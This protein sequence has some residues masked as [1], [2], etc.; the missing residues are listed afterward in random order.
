MYPQDPN[1]AYQ[2]PNMAYQDPNVAYQMQ[3]QGNVYM[4]YTF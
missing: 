4:V 3:M 1:L 2:D